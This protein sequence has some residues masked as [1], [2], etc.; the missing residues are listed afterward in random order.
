A[1]LSEQTDKLLTQIDY[2]QLTSYLC[3]S[4]SIYIPFSWDQLEEGSLNFKKTADKKF[5][6]EINLRLKEYGELNLMMALYAGNQLEI[7]AHTEKPE[8]K[9][10]IQ[11][12]IGEL[13][14]LLINAELTPR[15]IRVFEMRENLSPIS[16]GYSGYQHKSDLGF[17]VRV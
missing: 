2:H 16:K 11:D 1:K 12:N 6:C 5:Y 17:E 10:L 15:S 9:T 7:Q 8:L 13:R 4:N 14:S 3:A